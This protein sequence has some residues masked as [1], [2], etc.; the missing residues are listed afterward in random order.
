MITRL[1]EARYRMGNSHI[2]RKARTRTL[3][4]LGG[5]IEKAGL[6]DQFDLS[7]GQDLQRD[8][9]VKEDVMVLLGALS[10]L[11]QEMQRGDYSR[12]LWRERGIKAIGHD[13]E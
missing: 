6:F 8:E 9:E 13:L 11:T 12:D 3:I 10:S 1:T 5:L 2:M 7:L 4:Q